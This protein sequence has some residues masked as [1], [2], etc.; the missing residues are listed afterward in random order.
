[1]VQDS[2]IQLQPDTLTSAGTRGEVVKKGDGKYRN[3]VFAVLTF[4]PNVTLKS[5]R[6]SSEAGK[7]HIISF[8]PNF[9]ILMSFTFGRQRT[10]FAVLF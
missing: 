3:G 10:L 5:A 8:F 4:T 1:M 7:H 2:V 9:Q 6:F